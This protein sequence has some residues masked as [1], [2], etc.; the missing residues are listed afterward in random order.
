MPS[1]RG[2][3]KRTLDVLLALHILEICVVSIRLRLKQGAAIYPQRINN[4]LVCQEADRLRKGLDR[5]Y[6]DAIHHRSLPGIRLRNDESFESFLAGLD[7]NRQNTF[8]G[9]QHAVERQ[10]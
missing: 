5:E 8:D 1:G 6:V 4:L 9:P 10:F 7:G 3:L 2:D